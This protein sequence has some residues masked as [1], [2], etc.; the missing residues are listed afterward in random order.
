VTLG[1]YTVLG[2]VGKG[3]MGEVYA[4]Y[5]PELDR[6]IAIKLLRVGAREDSAATEGRIRLMREAQAIAK[7]SH[8]NVVTVY[9]VGTFEDNVFIAMQFV[10]GHTLRYWMLAQPRSWSEVVKI[11][12][13]AG[14]GLA[15]AHEKDLVHRDFKPDNVMVGDGHVRVMD[16]GLARAALDRKPAPRPPPG[17]APLVGVGVG[18]RVADLDSTRVLGQSS[19]PKCIVPEATSEALRLDLTQAGAV[20]GTPAYMS[21]EQFQGHAIDARSDQFSF[22]VALYEALYGE[23]PLAGTTLL[24]L[25][26]GVL[27]GTVRPAPA[28]SKVPSWVRKIVLRGL[29]VEPRDRWPSMTALLAELEKSRGSVPRRRFASGAAAKLAGIWEAPLR[30]RTGDTPVKAEVRS[31]FLATG[32]AYAAATFDKVLAILDRYAQSWTEMYVDACEATHVRGEQSADVLDLRMAGLEECL[33]GLRALSQAFR[34]ANAEVIENAVSAANALSRIDRCANIELLRAAVRPPEDPV[35]RAAVDRLR[36]QL[37]EVRVLHHV[38]RLNEGLEAIGP[39]VDEVRR[40]DYAP[41]LAETL[42]ELGYLHLEQGTAVTGA[43]FLE[44]A[45]WIAE[46]CRH[47]EIVAM[48]AAQLVYAV[49]DQLVRFDAG[50]IWARF[51][52]TR[53]RRMGGREDLWG[54]LY[55]NRGAMRE[56]EGRHHEAIDDAR[57]AVAA[58][59]KFHGPDSA[60]VGRSLSNMAVYMAGIGDL[61]NA[62]TYMQRGISAVEAGAGPDHPRIGVLLSNY[63]EI[64]NQL[65]RFAE[66][67]EM[68]RRS[69]AIFERESS[70]EGAVLS[71]PLT[72]LGLGYL[73]EGMAEEA[74]PP[75]ERAVAIRDRREKHPAN[76]GEVHFAL[77]RALGQVGR[78]APR[79]RALALAARA[80]YASDAPNES[81]QRWLA[82]I[83]A[84]LAADARAGADDSLAASARASAAGT[85]APAR[86]LSGSL[87]S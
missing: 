18:V 30:G 22:C 1:R 59:E 33:D 41:L 85:S 35:A 4:A 60:E 42:F 17:A 50:E 23:R 57:R 40:T 24:D 70:L 52:E 86:P 66:A 19:L 67:R 77:A 58:K 46:L 6:K 64:L 34:E 49:G 74:M 39:L 69:L 55:N 5:D 16:F 32:K 78:E 10:D 37:A 61:A 15:A 8:P 56:R 63:A 12:A 87:P 79:A 80:E 44:E 28:G 26:A 83:D 62:L 29:R 14:R 25:M 84:W 7:L 11:F 75:L 76:L 71:F 45:L 31:A 9:D 20:L 72:A 21:P 38:G 82:Q 47:D 65:G 73:G 53:L 43:Q 48:A 3:A 68:A 36:T 27:D 54:W 51:A 2:I 13:D 81:S